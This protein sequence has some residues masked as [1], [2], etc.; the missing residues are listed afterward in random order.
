MDDGKLRYT[1]LFLD[2]VDMVESGKKS[3]ISENRRL[4]YDYRPP[5]YSVIEPQLGNPNPRVRMETVLLLSNLKERRAIDR[6][7][8]LSVTDA[9]DAVRGACLAY[10]DVLRIDDVAAQDLLDEMRHSKGNTFRTAASKLR[11]IAKDTDVP[12]VR[13]IY[14]QVEE[15]LKRSV[16]SV[17][18]SI[19]DRYPELEPKRHLI[20][21]EPVFPDEKSLIRFLDKSIVYMDIRYRENC[22]GSSAI[23]VEMYNRIM[24]AFRKIQIRLYNEKTNLR[25]Y[26]DETRK[27]YAETEEL[28]VWATE[29][30][31]SKT[32]EGAEGGLQQHRCA[33]CGAKMGQTVSGWICPECGHKSG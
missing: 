24:A 14:G 32:A 16:L 9:D 17:L 29:D 2:S 22:Y 7:R 13:E 8:E 21:S 25:Y 26:S 27:M 6:I 30:L 20:T 12:A 10:A 15:E 33:R 4:V 23:S 28:L 3:S 18:E 31:L 11:Y 5:Y 1:E 19:V